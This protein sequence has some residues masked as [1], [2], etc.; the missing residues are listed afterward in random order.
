MGAEEI[1]ERSHKFGCTAAGVR[2]QLS[3][4]AGRDRGDQ[5]CGGGDDVG[6]VDGVAVICEVC[7]KVAPPGWY[8]RHALGPADR[9]GDDGVR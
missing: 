9:T 8:G 5:T 4:V 7:G 3:G 6:R 2:E 1:G